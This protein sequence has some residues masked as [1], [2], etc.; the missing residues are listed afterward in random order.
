MTPYEMA[1]KY[2]PRLWDIDRINA[3]FEAG[4]ITEEEYK[5]IINREGEP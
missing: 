1:Q 3:L 5:K 4:K 2:Y